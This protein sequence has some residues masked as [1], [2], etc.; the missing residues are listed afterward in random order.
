[1]HDVRLFFFGSSLCRCFVPTLSQHLTNGSDYILLIRD[2]LV[3][4]RLAERGRERPW[5]QYV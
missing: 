3:L 4:K 5:R 1:M 2:R